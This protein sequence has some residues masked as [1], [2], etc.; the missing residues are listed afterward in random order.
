[1]RVMRAGECCFTLSRKALLAPAVEMLC[2][3]AVARS[4]SNCRYGATE[5]FAAAA[6]E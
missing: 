3:A 1:M 6:V 5:A 2:R 4:R